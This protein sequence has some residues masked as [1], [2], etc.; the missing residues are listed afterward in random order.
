MQTAHDLFKHE[1]S[2]LLSGE[3]I[4]L[5]GLQ[6][7]AEKVQDPQLLKAIEAHRAQTEKQIQ[8][9]REAFASI[10]E[11]PEDTECHGMKGLVEEFR[12]FVEED[13]SEEVL[14]FFAVGANAKIEDYEVRAYESAIE[15]AKMMGHSKAERLLQQNLREEE[16][17]LKKLEQFEKKMLPQLPAGMGEDEET[18]LR[19]FKQSSQRRSNGSRSGGNSRSRTN[20]RSNSKKS[21]SRGGSSRSR[22]AA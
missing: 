7:Q 10:G 17:Q 3:Q 8:R 2:D 15:F 9:L 11:E 5:E 19:Q 13:P 12:S 1:M 20:A 14:A 21:S 22:R 4:A 16:A 18:T 6:E